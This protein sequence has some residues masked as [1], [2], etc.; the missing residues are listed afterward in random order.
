MPKPLTIAKGLSLPRADDADLYHPRRF[1]GDAVADW[2]AGAVNRKKLFANNIEINGI[3]KYLII[4]HKDAQENLFINCAVERN[5]GGNFDALFAGVKQLARE[6][7]C[8]GISANVTRD[9]LL[10]KVVSCGFR[11]KGITVEYA[12]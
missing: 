3:A 9:G 12:F 11:V 5:G 1:F 10:K 6:N 8:L 2:L 7:G 4:W